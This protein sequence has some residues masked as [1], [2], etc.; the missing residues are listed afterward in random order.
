M[1]KIIW[2]D[3]ELQRIKEHGETCLAVARQAMERSGIT[4]DNIEEINEHYE[5]HR[6]GSNADRAYRKRAV[7]K[8]ILK[9]ASNPLKYY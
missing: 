1:T 5:T 8:A 4:F 3:E 9:V 7:N 2:T 6:W